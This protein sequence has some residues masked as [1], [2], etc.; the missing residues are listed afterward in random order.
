MMRRFIMAVITAADGTATVRSP[1]VA[2]KIHSIRYVKT[3]FADG[4][5]FAITADATGENI[6]T[7]SN[8]NATT[9][10]YPRAPTHSQAGAAALYA[11]G[12]TGVLAP[13]AIASDKVK[14]V[15]AQAAT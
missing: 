14:I 12:G 5:D 4:V 11:S 7:E 6:W 10:R 9:D 15:I 2:G 13:I 1:R 8:V 3:D